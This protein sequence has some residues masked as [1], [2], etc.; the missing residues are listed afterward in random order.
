M[1]LPPAIDQSE[2][3]SVSLKCTTCK[4]LQPHMVLKIVPLSDDPNANVLDLLKNS[5]RLTLCQEC[6]TMKLIN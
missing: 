4:K 6:A 3:D 1:F 5:K 2:W